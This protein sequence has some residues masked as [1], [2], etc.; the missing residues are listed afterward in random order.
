[1]LT[2]HFFSFFLFCDLQDGLASDAVLAN[3]D[4]ICIDLAT[5]NYTD[6]NDD[7]QNSANNGQYDAT[8]HVDIK[9]DV[10][11]TITANT[12]SPSSSTKIDEKNTNLVTKNSDA[13]EFGTFS[14][15]SEN[16]P[17]KMSEHTDTKR[18]LNPS[19]NNILFEDMGE[20]HTKSDNPF[21][22]FTSSIQVT[23]KKIDK[24]QSIHSNN[25]K[26]KLKSFKSSVSG[27]G[28]F[29]RQEYS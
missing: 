29:V 17:Y 3:K 16:V 13:Q 26:K 2:S 27:S 14:F 8:S 24:V 25:S 4:E 18:K 15:S 7:V 11:H 10:I 1:M 9:Y 5:D 28:Q 22:T 23:Q 12:S 21:H 6:P 19:D 20:S